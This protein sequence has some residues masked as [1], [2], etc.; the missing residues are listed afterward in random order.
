MAGSTTEVHTGKINKIAYLLL[1]ISCICL[2]KCTSLTSRE[3]IRIL[4]TAGQG[5][6]SSL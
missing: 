6:P 2:Q 1:L 3:E 5:Q 4:F